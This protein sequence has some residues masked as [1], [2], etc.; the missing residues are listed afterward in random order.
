MPGPAKLDLVDVGINIPVLLTWLVGHEIPVTDGRPREG[1]WRFR[2]DGEI[3]LIKD[4]SGEQVPLNILKRPV[5]KAQDHVAPSKDQEP[6]P[7]QSLPT[8]AEDCL[9]ARGQQEAKGKRPRQARPGRRRL[10][11]AQKTD[12][13]SGWEPSPRAHT[14]SAM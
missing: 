14:V 12:R 7:E 5:V 1:P 6:D 13:A 9:Q 4:A 2:M 3:K 11:Q 10:M 8:T